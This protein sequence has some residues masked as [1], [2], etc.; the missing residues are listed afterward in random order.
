MSNKRIK[1]DYKK[2]PERIATVA[3]RDCR[4]KPLDERRRFIHY[5]EKQT[6]GAAAYDLY[7]PTDTPIKQGRNIVPLGFCMEMPDGYRAHIDA[8]SGYS[9]KAMEGYEPSEKTVELILT[10]HFEK[11]RKE[12]PMP[13]TLPIRW[14]YGPKRRAVIRAY[15]DD[16]VTAWAKRIDEELDKKALEIS[17]DPYIVAWENA[18]RYD[19]DVIQGKIDADYRGEVGVIICNRS[20]GAFWLKAGTR[21][22]QM[23]FLQVETAIWTE[24]DELTPTDR[25]AG[26]YGSTNITK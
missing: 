20:E 15:N 5:P 17:K 2:V 24:K 13:A 4:H 11:L 14:W 19:A 12:H 8:R 3:G 1:V 26:G 6:N 16:L 23:E 10:E 22:A 25:G 9:S 18:H 21:I 7:V